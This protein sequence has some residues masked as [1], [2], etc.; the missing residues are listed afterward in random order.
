MFHIAGKEIFFSSKKILNNSHGKKPFYVKVRS[1][2]LFRKLGKGQLGLE[3]FCE[4]MNFPPQ[5]TGAAYN[6]MVKVSLLPVYKRVVE[7]DMHE[8]AFDLCS[9]FQINIDKED[10]SYITITTVRE[11]EKSWLD[12]NGV[13]AA[14]TIEKNNQS[15]E[16]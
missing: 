1:I 10:I 15:C 3:I 4:Y 2:L 9:S 12:L 7:S 14:I 13:A 6:R 5:I 11:K 8:A 16:M